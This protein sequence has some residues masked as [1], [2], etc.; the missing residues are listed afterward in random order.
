MV[1]GAGDVCGRVCES[2]EG[3]GEGEVGGL[4]VLAAADGVGG[5]EW[6]GGV[7]YVGDVEGGWW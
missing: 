4:V 2:A 3:G 7:E 1:C 5:H 6:V